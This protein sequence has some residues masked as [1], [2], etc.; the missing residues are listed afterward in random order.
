MQP[1]TSII[2]PNYNYGKY[3]R[4]CLAS[5]FDQ[6]YRNLQVILVDDGSTDNSLEIANLYAPKLHLIQNSHGGVNRARNTGIKFAEGK[7]IG[8]CDSDDIWKS[9]KISS[10]VNFMEQNLEFGLIYC[11]IDYVAE[12]RKFLKSQKPKYSGDCRLDF[13]RHPGEAIV[14]LGASTALMRSEN[15]RQIVGF[16]ENLKM[17]GEDLDFFRRMSEVTKFSFLTESLVEYRQHEL[18][19][20]RV[21]HDAYFKGN[22]EVL[23]KLFKENDFSFVQ[24]RIS[25]LKLHWMFFKTEVKN[26]HLLSSLRQILFAISPIKF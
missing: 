11:G 6:D 12:N 17:P 15:V 25:W 21:S 26:R 20:S 7:Y 8:F 19:A 3:L 9:D 4:D 24:C 13:L 22:K 10:Q 16:D 14:L 18:S 5:I 1:L 23:I 2:I